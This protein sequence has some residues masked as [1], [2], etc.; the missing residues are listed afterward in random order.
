M[1]VRV[2]LLGSLR[3]PDVPREIEINLQADSKI[4]ILIQELSK[5]FP[6]ID[7]TISNPSAG[8]LILLRGV[9]IGNL[10]G[11]DTPLDEDSEIVLVPVTHGG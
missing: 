10:N 2:R 7:P 4:H 8:N 1:I 9:E 5:L 3:P 6:E 11:L